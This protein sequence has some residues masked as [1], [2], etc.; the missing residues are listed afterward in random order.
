MRRSIILSLIFCWPLYTYAQ[1][2]FTEYRETIPAFGLCL[3]PNNTSF[4]TIEAD[5]DGMFITE[6][7]LADF[8]EL[9]RFQLNEELVNWTYYDYWVL[10]NRG[11]DVPRERV[12]Y[13]MVAGPKGVFVAVNLNS[14]SVYNTEIKVFN[15][16]SKVLAGTVDIFDADEYVEHI[17]FLKFDSNGEHLLVGSEANGTF[18]VNLNN[19]EVDKFS[20]AN[21]YRLVNY[22]YKESAMYF[23][24]FSRDDYGV[25]TF[26]KGFIRN[27]GGESQQIDSYSATRDYTRYYTPLEMNKLFQPFYRQSYDTYITSS[28]GTLQTILYRNRETFQII[29]YEQESSFD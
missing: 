19:F 22:D 12:D 9:K 18:L 1:E 5:Y 2:T 6:H 3:M 20:V 11:T 4:L 28:D 14:E 17:S 27:T 10:N 25:I 7:E 8:F 24:P 13:N 21:N 29:T 16:E 23:A 15:L 26:G